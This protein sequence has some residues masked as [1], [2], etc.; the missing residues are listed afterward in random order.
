MLGDPAVQQFLPKSSQAHNLFVPMSHFCDLW[1]RTILLKSRDH[2]LVYFHKRC[3]C[4]GGATSDFR[5]FLL[6]TSVPRTSGPKRRFACHNPTRSLGELACAMAARR[7][8]EANKRI[9]VTPAQNAF[10]EPLFSLLR[11]RPGPVEPP[12]PVREKRPIFHPQAQLNDFRRDAY[13]QRGLFA[14]QNPP[15]THP[16]FNRIC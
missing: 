7:S 9:S 12:I 10:L 3:S 15:P 16:N 1:C 14:P 4:C 2:R 11:I 8:A 6:V 13:Q 5:L